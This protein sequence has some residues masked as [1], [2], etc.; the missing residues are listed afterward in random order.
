MAGS[1]KWMNY[2]ADDGTLYAVLID[3]DNGEACD[4]L[5]Y[6][7]TADG[8]V[9]PKYFNMRYVNA[10]SATGVT[11]KFYVG[12]PDSTLLAGGGS[13]TVG[14]TAYAIS[15]KRGESRRLPRAADTGQQ[16]GDAT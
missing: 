9:M 15:S 14:G 4:F 8:A 10:I 7:G 12:T 1:I 5:D 6:S 2:T 11:R 16:D 13:V 3:E